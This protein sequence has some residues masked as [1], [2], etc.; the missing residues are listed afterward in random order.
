M[1]PACCSPRS[2][3]WAQT[4]VIRLL[5]AA[6]LTLTLGGCAAPTSLVPLTATLTTA[7]R[8][9]PARQIV[10]TF[11]D[12]H[13][14]LKTDAGASPRA[15]ADTS[16][17]DGALQS[18]AL[19]RRI[20]A[21]YT[22]R[23]VSG[24]RIASLEVYCAVFE[25][26]SE[27]AMESTLA[28]LRRDSRIESAEPMR[29]FTTSL[30]SRTYDDPYFALQRGIAR[31]RVPEAQQ[32]ARGRGITIALIDTGVDRTHPDLAARI[33]ETQNF[34]DSDAAAF[35]HDRHGTAIAGII[36]ATSNNG[37]GI[38]GV[39]PE[40]RLLAYKACW[41][42]RSASTAVCNTLTLAAALD[43]AIERRAR[44]INLSLVGP[45]DPLLARLVIVAQQRGA[46]VVGASSNQPGEG[47]PG[48]VAGVLVVADS[49]AALR[50]VAY[51]QQTALLGAP[52]QDAL[53]LLP[54]GRYDYVSGASASTAMVSGVVAL[55]LQ[56]WPRAE[57]M[58]VI[59]RLRRTAS[60]GPAT[61]R[62]V[63]AWAA[64][65]DTADAN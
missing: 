3:N 48:A 12:T 28:R 21:Q 1:N 49:D 10:V 29:Q 24:W 32:V 39:A 7:E 62:L 15:Y 55:A 59:E 14:S 63:D 8:A 25:L 26:A 34:V 31:I 58:A 65:T 51:A 53:T 13:S 16:R 56:R 23:P 19:A 61:V 35:Q 57:P 17:Y 41:T 27:A 64:V 4:L 37:I 30:A 42:E 5:V 44:I 11:R 38:V 46:I 47:F 43:T 2:C 18:S 36:A 50:P 6:W 40:A 54:G 20:A 45:N 33:V 22:L 60:A 9:D 52:G